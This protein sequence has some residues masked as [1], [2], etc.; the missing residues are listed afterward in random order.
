MKN[1]FEKLFFYIQGLI[2]QKVKAD[3]D[4]EDDDEDIDAI[5]SQEGQNPGFSPPK[6]AFKRG[7]I[8]K[9]PHSR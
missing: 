5:L 6:K 2:D 9:R 3:E 1:F 4:F 8:F 7:K